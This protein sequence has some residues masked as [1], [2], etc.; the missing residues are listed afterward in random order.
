MR[1]A[2][3]RLEHTADAL[4]RRIRVVGRVFGQKLEHLSL[5]L[6]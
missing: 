1:L 3:L 6:A 4:P 2:R 5:L